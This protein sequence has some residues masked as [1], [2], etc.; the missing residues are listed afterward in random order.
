M[1][2]RIADALAT[3][4]KVVRAAG[5]IPRIGRPVAVVTL[6]AYNRVIRHLEA[7]EQIEEESPHLISVFGALCDE[8][9][10]PVEGDPVSRLK[11]YLRNQ[12]LSQRLWRLVAHSNGRLL[13][14]LKEFYCGNAHLAEPALDHLRLLD[15]LNIQRQPPPWF[16]EVLL[17][18]WGSITNQRHSYLEEA[19][20]ALDEWRH[21]A[22]L[23]CAGKE[24]GSK[25]IPPTDFALVQ[26]WLLRRDCHKV[27]DK[28]RRKAGWQWLVRQAK[29]WRK[30]EQLKLSS[31][32]WY[33]PFDGL[34]VLQHDF[35]A[36]TSVLHLWEEA[37]TMRHCVED[38]EQACREGVSVILSVRRCGKRVATVDLARGLDGWE[39]RHI[40]GFANRIA[41]RMAA[42]ATQAMIRVISRVPQQPV[43][44]QAQ[45]EASGVGRSGE[46]D[47]VIAVD[48][49][50]VNDGANTNITAT[51][52]DHT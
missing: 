36:L 37:T 29:A 35:I 7:F 47:I 9:D 27:L 18:G 39:V 45:L 43:Q 38:Y 4:S 49:G 1:R 6:G 33:V 42:A 46:S 34:R 13:I 44:G 20:P 40:A 16:I 19:A 30:H 5:R 12:G 14:P 15:L 28:R 32:T 10:F 8:F 11:R 22:R 21:V 23:V 2:R 3:D 48:D 41:D 50:P 31:R 26:Q 24:S 52:F 51:R 25:N 17:S